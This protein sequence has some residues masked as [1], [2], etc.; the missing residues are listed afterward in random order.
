MGTSKKLLA[1]GAALALGLPVS[2]LT[3]TSL[4]S[5][6]DHLDP[7]TRTDPAMTS[8]PD[9]AADIADLYA[10]HTADN[11]I[12]AITFA[13]PQP[14]TKKAY[15]DRDVLYTINVS[16]AGAAT[17]AEIPIEVRFAQDAADPNAYGV[18]I[19]GLPGGTIQGPV[20]TTLTSA[21]GIL[22]KAGLVDDPFFFD[23][24]GFH[25][26]QNTGV[27]SIKNTRNFFA[28]Q[29]DTAVILQIP[30]ALIANGTN[31]LN[32]WATTARAKIGA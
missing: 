30:R 29:N 19:K 20:E 21:N 10:W 12:V 6:A 18:Q 2:V 8:N 23:L 31:P 13:G 28:G 9:T 5:A 26:T 22:A 27:L 4:G 25:E 16:N 1:L 3:A 7:P 15:Y 11:V 32:I 14:G 17:D 24:Q